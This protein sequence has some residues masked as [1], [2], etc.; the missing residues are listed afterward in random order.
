MI[1]AAS[2]ELHSVSVLRS[3]TTVSISYG[4]ARSPQISSMRCSIRPCYK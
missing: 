1:D 2:Y 4:T 3:L